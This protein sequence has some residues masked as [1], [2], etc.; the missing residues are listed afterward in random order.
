MDDIC[1]MMEN[2]VPYDPHEE[3]RIL[4]ISRSMSIYTLS[5]SIFLKET[6]NRYRKYLT[7]V[8][9]SKYKHCGF[10]IQILI[11]EFLQYE[12]TNYNN[13]YLAAK[14]IVIDSKI[15]DIV[16]VDDAI[17]SDE[18]DQTQEYDSY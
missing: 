7:Y 17:T 1:N 8:D 18:E 11:N 4:Q 13:L 5:G 10:L 16:D 15:S 9:F 14:C 6:F 3:Y 12:N 2:L